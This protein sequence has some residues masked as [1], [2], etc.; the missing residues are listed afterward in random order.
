MRSP[1]DTFGQR[2]WAGSSASGSVLDSLRA[3]ART[4]ADIP[5][6]ASAVTAAVTTIED[7]RYSVWA[8]PI[9][10]K[11]SETMTGV[12]TQPA[13]GQFRYRAGGELG[14]RDL[15]TLSGATPARG[16]PWSAMAFWDGTSFRGILVSAWTGDTITGSN[17]VVSGARPVTTPASMFSPTT[18]DSLFR[19]IRPLV[20]EA[21]GTLTLDGSLANTGVQ[22]SSAQNPSANGY[23]STSFF[24]Q[25][26]GVWG[27]RPGAML[28]GDTPGPALTTGGYGISA[29]QASEPVTTYYWGG[30]A[31]ASS[32]YVGVVFSA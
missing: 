3:L 29:Y 12:Q 10:A 5:A 4:L 14:T 30:T 18:G 32:N 28:D 11:M 13:A 21:D 7:H 24:S 17:V 19:R 25:D 26:D 9:P 23:Y 22:F 16:L 6:T 2:T 20:I 15:G 8:V 31:E 1:F 27:F